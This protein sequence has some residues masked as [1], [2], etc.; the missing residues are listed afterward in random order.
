GI[1]PILGTQLPVLVENDIR[2]VNLLAQNAEGWG[3]ILA[4]VTASN[5]HS[6]SPHTKCVSLDTL[7]QHAAGVLCLSGGARFGLLPNE[8]LFRTLASH[9]NQRFYIELQRHDL[10]EEKISEPAYIALAESLNVPLVATNDSRFLTPSEAKAYNALVCIGEGLT[11]DSPDH[12]TYTEAYA[13]RSPAEMLRLFADVPEANANTVAIAQRC[14][15][16]LEGVDV[17]KMFLPQWPVAAGESVPEILRAETLK[18]LEQRLAEH[19]FPLYPDAIDAKRAEYLKRM[20][21]ELEVIITMGFDSYFLITSDFIRWAKSQDIPVGPGRGS[22]AGSLVAWALS[23]TDLDPIRWALYFERFLNPERVSLPDFDIDFCQ[24]RRDEVIKYVQQKYGEDR[25]SQIITFG[26]LKA[27]ACIRDVGRVLQLPYNLVNRICAFVPEVPNPPSI[28]EILKT[29]DRLQTVQR[30]EPAVPELLE[31]AQQL[32]GCLRHAST[33]AAGVIIADRPI[34]AVCGLYQDP[35]SPMPATQFDMKHAEYAGLVKFDFLGLKTLTQVKKTADILAAEGIYID[36]LKLPLDD[37][38]TYTMLCAGHTVGVFQ[39]ESGGMTD[40]TKQIQPKDMEQLSAIICLYR[41]GP[42]ELLPEFVACHLGKKKPQYAHEK[43]IPILQDTHGVAIYQEQVMMMAR[44]LAGYT[45]GGADMLRRAM[46]KKDPKEMAKQREIFVAG[47]GRENQIDPKR[48][49]EIFDAMSAF[50]GYGFN[51]AHTMAYTLVSYQTAY[52]KAHHPLP[53][54][55]A[56]MTLDRGNT[57]KLLRYKNDL[58]RMNVP[59]LPPCVNNSGVMFQVEKDA[60]KKPYAIRHALAAIKG[61]GEDAMGHIVTERQTGG[62]YKD[63]WDFL[64][65]HSPHVLGKKPLE[66]L[67]KAGALDSLYPN[68]AELLANVDKLQAHVQ[69]VWDAKNSDQI[70]LFGEPSGGSSALQIPTLTKT[71]SWHKGEQAAQELTVIGFYLSA[72]PLSA[73]RTD[74]ESIKGLVNIA[75]LA[76]LAAAGRASAKIAG[77]VLTTRE[78]KTKKGDRMGFATL[79]DESG[80]EEL[81]LFPEAYAR[82]AEHLGGQTPLVL[83]IAMSIDGE[84]LRLNVELLKKLEDVSKQRSHIRLRV[85][86]PASLQPLQQ[87]LIGQKGNTHCEL[88]IARPQAQGGD[89]TLRLPHGIACTAQLLSA[90][91]NAEGVRVL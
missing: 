77:V 12:V 17:K 54:M 47:C 78:L 66:V 58:A 52:L 75:Q 8:G 88:I 53:F 46:G 63:L 5:L 15:F 64:S 45:L 76:E 38:P 62:A 33:H 44:L 43:L 14:S 89:V 19:V 83:D 20:E 27:R 48:A 72:H 68:R 80:Q 74:I 23:I 60:N 84:R 90:L 50:A 34:A 35:R 4:L 21:M 10:V 86:N 9:F 65:R 42:M 85:E 29:D 79:T 18:G 13:L 3:N 41:P 22:G 16:W 6:A 49:N 82:Y 51:K 61:A 2:L 32:E 40:L 7:C 39:I 69:H 59:L 11:V 30:E 37:A 31:I 70:G 26:S 57:D 67:I 55:A 1:Q 36:P 71:P 56:T 25:V 73:F 91:E 81:V 24:E 87:L 28:A